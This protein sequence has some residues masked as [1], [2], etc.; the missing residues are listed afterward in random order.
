MTVALRRTRLLA[1]LA[2]GALALTLA[3]PVTNSGAAV[4]AAVRAPAV[5]AGADG[6]VIVVEDQ[7][8]FSGFDIATDPSTGV[9]YLGW[10]SSTAAAPTRTV[11]LCVLPPGALACS[12]GVLSTSAVDWPSASGLQVEVTAPGTATLVWYHNFGSNTLGAIS[13]A[14]YAGGVLSAPATAAGHIPPNGLLFDVTRGP[15][16]ALWAVTRDG[17]F[18]QSLQIVPNVAVAAAQ[19][20]VGAP[21]MVGNASLAFNGSQPVLLIAKAGSIGDPLA[22]ASGNPL[23]SFKSLAKT[24]TTGAGNDLVGTSRGVRALASEA[25]AS[26][27][28]AVAKWNGSEFSEPELIGEDN[29]CPGLFHDAG[30]DGSG[31]IADVVERCGKVIIYN[32]PDTEN[33]AEASFPTG[34]TLAAGGAQI[35]STTRGYGWVA[36]GTLSPTNVASRLQVRAVRLPALMIEKSKN[37]NPGKVTVKGPASCLPVVE[38]KAKVSGKAKNGW[39]VA[40]KE[41]TLDGKGNDATVKLDGEKLDSGEKYTLLGKVVFKKGGQTATVTQKLKFKVC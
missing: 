12:G 11:H 14:T 15:D 18:G 8:T 4:D 22:Y 34:G 9:A 13:T 5:K 35:T 10:I 23:G 19:P 20:P 27:Y 32:L 37:A 29:N 21:W 41:L 30:T 38:V 39:S 40:N 3:G 1:A 26:Y 17:G 7:A 24:W 16:G 2:A 6:P 31:R 36:W 25:K 33:A 28:P